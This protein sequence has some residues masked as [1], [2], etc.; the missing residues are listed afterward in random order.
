MHEPVTKTASA[1]GSFHVKRFIVGGVLRFLVS[2]QSKL[3][4]DCPKWKLKHSSFSSYSTLLPFS[5][6]I[7]F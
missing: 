4:L 3:K 6:T 2:K 7:L 5:P 1:L